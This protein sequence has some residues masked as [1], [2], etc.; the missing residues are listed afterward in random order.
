MTASAAAVK[1]IQNSGLEVM[2]R[3]IVGF[4]SDTVGIFER[5]SSFIERSGIV[6]A[7]VGLLMA[8]PET[9]LFSRLKQEDRIVHDST[10][11]NVDGVQAG[12]VVAFEMSE[13]SHMDSLGISAL[14]DF[15][16]TARK[17]Q[18]TIEIQNPSAYVF[19]MLELV[20][21]QRLFKIIA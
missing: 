4:D 18:I 21:V 1:K 17:H 11:N 5:Q 2:G 15:S 6:T 12:G 10:G 20:K 8:L 19:K 9:R 3:F 13:V 7:M 16:D 14:I